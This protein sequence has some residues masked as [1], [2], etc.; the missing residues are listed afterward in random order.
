MKDLDNINAVGNRL[1]F[2]VVLCFVAFGFSMLSEG[3]LNQYFSIISVVLTCVAIPVTYLWGGVAIHGGT[4]SGRDWRWFQPLRGGIRFVIF[5]A[6]GWSFF[7]LSFLLPAVPWIAAW[8][9]PGVVV[10][11]LTVAGGA[12]AV[13]SQL[14]MVT[15]LLS[16]KKPKSTKKGTGKKIKKNQKNQKNQKQDDV[17][18][19]GENTRDEDVV[20]IVNHRFS[21]LQTFIHSDSGKL[22]WRS[23]LG[24]QFG[25][26]LVGC[27]VAVVA[28]LWMTDYVGHHAVLGCFSLACVAV[29]VGV[30]HGV[31]GSWAYFDKNWQ[32]ILPGGSYIF[33]SLQTLG[34]TFFS[35]AI[36]IFLLQIF[37]FHAA[38]PL[39]TGGVSG[40][41]A[42]VL[43]AGSLLTRGPSSAPSRCR[44]P[45]TSSR[46]ERKRSSSAG[47]TS[48]AGAAAMNKENEEVVEGVEEVEEEVEEVDKEVEEVEVA[49]VAEVVE[50]EVEEEEDFNDSLSNFNSLDGQ[51]TEVSYPKSFTH[52]ADGVTLWTMLL[53][54]ILVTFIYNTQNLVFFLVVF[55][56]ILA[57]VYPKTIVTLWIL[58][59]LLYPLTFYNAPMTKGTRAV[60]WFQ[61]HWMFKHI[62]AYFDLKIIY[63]DVKPLSPDSRYIFGFH[64]HGII[65]LTIGWACLSDLWQKIFPNIHPAA[66][67]SSVLHVVPFTRDLN[68]MFGGYAVTRIGFLAAL[69]R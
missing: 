1:L 59:I 5:Q 60:K 30:T 13:L 24:I 51:V 68:Q 20:D 65:P 17:N 15:S 37:Q 66:L 38:P 69:K 21:H 39:V 50:G 47:L 26:V 3:Y 62:A 28:D 23:F 4:D 58:G 46:T 31:G 61:G 55:N 49:E 29:G 64:P 34:W 43:L 2:A 32:F 25:L 63:D 54:T 10:K 12:S 44:M 8:Y 45:G 16:Y 9:Y 52:Y 57:N 11:G 22:W 6:L 35:M 36:L 14:L 33:V 53:R 18:I 7:A 27:G 19:G 56:V 42:D 67:A 48:S 40:L 41:I